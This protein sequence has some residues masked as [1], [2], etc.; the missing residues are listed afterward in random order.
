MGD[1]KIRANDEMYHYEENSVFF[2]FYQLGVLVPTI[3]IAKLRKRVV[4]FLNCCL[5][6]FL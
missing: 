2:S 1:L 5:F 4:V 3:G 6:T